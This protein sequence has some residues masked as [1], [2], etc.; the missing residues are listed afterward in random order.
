MLEIYKQRY[1]P[2]WR[3]DPISY[4]QDQEFICNAHDYAV[5]EAVVKSQ[6]TQLLITDLKYILDDEDVET[7]PI[8]FGGYLQKI[9]T[10]KMVTY[11]LTPEANSPHEDAL[12]FIVKEAEVEDNGDIA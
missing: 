8:G 4:Y 12:N 7:L 1:T 3:E 10:P 11:R 2:N 5:A 9:K 6:I